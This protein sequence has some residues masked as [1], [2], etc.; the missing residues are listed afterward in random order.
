MKN[1]NHDHCQLEM[2]EGVAGRQ[3]NHHKL[4]RRGGY[5]RTGDPS[6]FDQSA[7]KNSRDARMN[8]LRA[9]G[10]QQH[11]LKIADEI[12]VDEFLKIWRI[13]DRELQSGESSSSG[14]LIVPLRLY[15]TY[16]RYQ[17]N[18]YIESLANEGNPP[19][20]IR[21]KLMTLLHEK[22][23]IRNILAVIKKCH[24]AAPERSQS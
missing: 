7:E 20:I 6:N 4:R 14:R 16:L 12:G 23:S 22:I 13:L 17:R 3:I 2:F 5:Q 21:R 24:D 1:N 9:M 11:W 10:L 19:R 8:E 15:S 18:R